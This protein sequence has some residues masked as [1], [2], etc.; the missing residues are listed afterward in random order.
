MS[1]IS[2]REASGKPGARGKGAKPTVSERP[3]ARAEMWAQV[4]PKGTIRFVDTKSTCEW[5]AAIYP[6]SRCRIVRVRVEEI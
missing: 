1:H 4:T 3:K 2:Q 5:V 6:R